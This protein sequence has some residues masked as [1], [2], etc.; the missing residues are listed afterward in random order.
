[1]NSISYEFCGCDVHKTNIEVAWLDV[2]GQHFKHGSFKN[3][4]TGNKLFWRTCRRLETKYVAMESTGIY[5]KG[6]QRSHPN[7]IETI[8]FNSATIKLK[9]RP[10]TDTKDAMR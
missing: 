10:K 2:T 1:M 4:Q 5:W 9:T 6:L 8:V 3:S 7:L